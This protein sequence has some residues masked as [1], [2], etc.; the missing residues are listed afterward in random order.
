MLK[1]GLVRLFA[2]YRAAMLAELTETLRQDQQSHRAALLAQA[3][4]FEAALQAQRQAFHLELDALR[5]ELQAERH[6]FQAALEEFRFLNR[7]QSAA[8]SGERNSH[9]QIEHLAKN[10][11]A[12]LLTLVLNGAPVQGI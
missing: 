6:S 9:A 2:R 7:H 1:A 11:D 12:A 8:L 10:I 5:A 4:A 3:E